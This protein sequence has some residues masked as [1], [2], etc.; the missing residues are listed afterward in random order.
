MSIHILQNAL[1]L[2]ISLVNSSS[3]IILFFNNSLALSSVT[4]LICS[5]LPSF[6]VPMFKCL[7]TLTDIGVSFFE[8]KLYVPHKKVPPCAPT[9]AAF[10]ASGILQNVEYFK[11]ISCLILLIPRP[12]RNN[13][14]VTRSAQIRLH[15]R[16]YYSLPQ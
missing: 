5:S 3:P 9:C 2:F 16:S 7:Q 4:S 1:R 11:A 15:V 8:H 14:P 10:G 12:L 13:H 6:V